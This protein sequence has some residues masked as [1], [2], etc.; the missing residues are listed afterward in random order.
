[1]QLLIKVHL[2]DHNGRRYW[3]FIPWPPTDTLNFGNKGF[4]LF[5]DWS[6]YGFPELERN[7]LFRMSPV[8]LVHG[9]LLKVSIFWLLVAVTYLGLSFL[10]PSTRMLV[11]IFLLC[12]VRDPIEDL[13]L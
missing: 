2:C 7:L 5:P 8:Q 4:R 12:A 3:P 6:N 11:G 13:H 10:F 1:M 9:K